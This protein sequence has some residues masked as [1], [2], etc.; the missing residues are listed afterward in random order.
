MSSLTDLQRRLSSV[1]ALRKQIEQH[2]RPLIMRAQ[3]ALNTARAAL[4]KMDSPLADEQRRL[5]R[6]ISAHERQGALAAEREASM[7]S[8][9]D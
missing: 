7:S 2:H 4:R 8:L 9:T 1:R 6:E 5:E 3:E